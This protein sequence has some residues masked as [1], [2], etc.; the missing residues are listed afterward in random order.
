M[1]GHYDDPLR[2]EAPQEIEE[3]LWTALRAKQ[4]ELAAEAASELTGNVGYFRNRPVEGERWS[5]L[6]E[7][8]LDRI[9]GHEQLRSW[10]LQDRADMRLAVGE[11]REALRLIR[12]ALALKRKALPSG[13]PDIALSISTEGVMLHELGDDEAAL[14]SAIEANRL[15]TEAYGP[16][17][18]LVATARGNEGEYLVALGRSQEALPLLRDAVARMESNLGSDHPFLAYPLT[19]MG[20]ALLALGRPA[21]AR[22]SLEHAARIRQ[23]REPNPTL[24]AE[25]RFLLAQ[26]HWAAGD[27]RRARELAATAQVEYAQSPAGKKAG[28][29]VAAWLAGHA[30]SW[31]Q[32]TPP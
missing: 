19:A 25:T 3:A 26:A 32:R 9:G 12:E 30:Q 16:R 18:P 21:E 29:K 31:Q 22:R 10:V 4:D 23:A 15:V 17:S 8:L 5:Q 11:P 2:P 20:R 6:A 14:K 28:D 24:R 7:S 13:H 1:L 27:Q